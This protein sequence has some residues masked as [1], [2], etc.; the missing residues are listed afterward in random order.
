MDKN[1]NL[2]GGIKVLVCKQL[3]PKMLEDGSNK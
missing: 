2:T 1:G 3:F